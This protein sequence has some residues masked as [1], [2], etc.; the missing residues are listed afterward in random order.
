M[1]PHLEY[2]VP[3]WSPWNQGDKDVLEKV[4]KRAIGMVTNFKGRTYEEK[5]SEAGMIT[6][7]ARRRRGDLLQA[8]RTINGVD[9]VDSSQWFQMVQPRVGASTE[10]PGWSRNSSGGLNVERGEGRN[11][12]RRSF[13]SQ[14]VTEP[15]NRLPNEVK[16]AETL[17]MCKNGIDN[18]I[19][20]RHLANARP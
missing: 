16:K 3:A 11:A 10:N 9:D 6:L 19:F 2:C 20:R 12:F 1:R 14:R 8:Y 5:L 13:W 17:N 18:L 7:E 15:W 4:Q